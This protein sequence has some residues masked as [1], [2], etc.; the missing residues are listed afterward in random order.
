[1]T[2]LLD[3]MS[4]CIDSGAHYTMIE[5]FINKINKTVLRDSHCS[6][7]AHLKIE[8][9]IYDTIFNETELPNRIASQHCIENLTKKLKER[10]NI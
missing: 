10:N 8:S 9:R 6:F 5:T 2:K 7:M 1:M 4:F 3:I